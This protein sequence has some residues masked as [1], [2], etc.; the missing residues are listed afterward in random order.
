MKFVITIRIVSKITNGSELKK[1]KMTKI[2][3]NIKENKNNTNFGKLVEINHAE[4]ALSPK[5]KPDLDYAYARLCKMLSSSVC[6]YRYT[7]LND[8]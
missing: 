7:L 5:G 4:E 8:R 2:N 1:E 3:N 6:T